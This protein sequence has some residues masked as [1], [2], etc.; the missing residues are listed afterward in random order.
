MTLPRGATG[1]DAPVDDPVADLRTFTGY[2][3]HAA[4]VVGGAV[5]GVTPAGLTSNFHAV[6]PAA[7]NT[8]ALT[9]K[10]A[11]EGPL[12]GGRPRPAAGLSSFRVSRS[13]S[14]WCPGPC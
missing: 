13:G 1:F 7:T 8:R 10:P 14:R 5:T 12:P 6:L 2:C 11:G 9:C 4:R 3:H